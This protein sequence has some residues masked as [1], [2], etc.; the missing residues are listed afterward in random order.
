MVEVQD[1]LAPTLFDPE[2]PR[3]KTEKAE[4]SIR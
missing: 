1:G 4:S 3:F 2:K